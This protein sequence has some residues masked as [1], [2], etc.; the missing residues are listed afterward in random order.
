[1][2]KRTSREVFGHAKKLHRNMTPA[3][4]A[5]FISIKII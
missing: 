3:D 1:M 4:P 5:T 2:H